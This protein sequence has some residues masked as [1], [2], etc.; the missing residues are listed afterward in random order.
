MPRP[1]NTCPVG[2]DSL[3]GIKRQ[4]TNPARWETQ[5]WREFAAAIRQQGIAL[6]ETTAARGAFATD[7]GARLTDRRTVS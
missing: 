4:R 3:L 7:A 1:Y 6:L 5:S 2:A